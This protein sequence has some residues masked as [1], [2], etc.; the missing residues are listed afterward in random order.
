V[1]GGTDKIG[2][3]ASWQVELRGA[4]TGDAGVDAPLRQTPLDLLRGDASDGEGDDSAASQPLIVH[5]YPGDFLEPTA[6]GLRQRGHPVPDGVQAPGLG[7]FGGDTEADLARVVGFPVLKAP[8]VVADLERSRCGPGRGMQIEEWRLQLAEQRSAHVQET[9]TA[10]AAPGLAAGAGKHVA[11]DPPD[12]DR[13]LPDRLAGVQQEGNP[14]PPGDRTDLFRGV[15]QAAL[16]R[17][18]RHRDE[19]HFARTM[20]QPV[21]QI[22][23]GKLAVLIVVY[24]LHDRAGSRG[25]LE[26]G[27]RVARVL[28]VGG[29]DAVT[30]IE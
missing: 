16:R 19:L 28:G 26:V 25:D 14:G 2:Q 4:D 8:R 20:L 1:H 23:D 5:R 24:D 30:R 6:Q 18:V 7:V 3:A 12:V 10:R 21:L 13:E 11:A 9:G 27:D 29:Q 15:D 22:G 17:Y